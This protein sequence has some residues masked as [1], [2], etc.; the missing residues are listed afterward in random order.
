VITAQV[1]ATSTAA[2]IDNT[3]KVTYQNKNHVDGE[4]DSETPP[5]PP[6]TV[7]T[8]P[9]TKKINE[10]LDH[11]DT[12]TQ[13]NY[14]YNIKTVLPTDIATYKRFVITDSLESELAVQGIPTMTGDAA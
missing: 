11:L 1:K 8:P 13:T 3:A 6:V 12:A 14:T 9:V 7:T 2:K 5:T 10:S 4:P